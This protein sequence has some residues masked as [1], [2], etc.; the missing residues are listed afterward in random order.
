MT[1]T[2]LPVSGS[3]TPSGT[4]AFFNGSTYLGTS[5]VTAGVATYDYNPSSLSANTYPITAAYSG[6][7]TFVSF[8]SPRRLSPWSLH[9]YR[10]RAISCQS[11]PPL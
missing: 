2:V 3:G 6:D 7:S 8:D 5:A 9:P 10:I 11:I 4:I 1:A